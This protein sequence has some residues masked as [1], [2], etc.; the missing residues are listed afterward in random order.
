MQYV[1]KVQD[2]S[3]ALHPGLPAI[4]SAQGACIVCHV[5]MHS[6]ACVMFHAPLTDECM[7]LLPRPVA[8]IV[9]QQI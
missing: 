3:S 8:Y 2:D 7:T 6:Q 1:K 5:R 9:P 4:D